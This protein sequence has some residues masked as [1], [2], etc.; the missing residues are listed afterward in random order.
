M[1]TY[2][3][4]IDFSNKLQIRILD[5]VLFIPEFGSEIVSDPGSSTHIHLGFKCFLCNLAQLFFCTSC[6]KIKFDFCCIRDPE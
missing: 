1:N 2:S 6:S 5:P 4:L 3:I